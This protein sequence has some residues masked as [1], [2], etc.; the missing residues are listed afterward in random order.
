MQNEVF[1][2]RGLVDNSGGQTTI[3]S[4]KVVLREKVKLVSVYEYTDVTNKEF[5][6]YTCPNSIQVGTSLPFNVE[7]KVPLEVLGYTAIGNVI[8]RAYFLELVAEVNCCYSNPRISKHIIL[9]NTI[10]PE[11]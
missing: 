8:Y 7:L 5:V 4:F 9:N 11:V 1:H 6:L 2:A 3:K 10:Q